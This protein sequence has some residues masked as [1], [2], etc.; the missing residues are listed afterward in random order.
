[1]QAN[2]RHTT[3][4]GLTLQAAYTY[5]HMID[6]STTAYQMSSV[7]ENYDMKRWKA[8]ADLNRTQ[9]LS[10]N[11]IYN[12]PFFKNSKSALLRQSVGGWQ[13]S[14]ITAVMTGPPTGFYGCGVNGFNTGIGGSYDCNPIG[15]LKISKAFTTI[16]RTGR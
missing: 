15:P 8:T 5:S 10:V 6:N 11:Y 1:M 13:V 3:G 9:V 7:D 14:G 4:Y 12:L 2:L 16:L